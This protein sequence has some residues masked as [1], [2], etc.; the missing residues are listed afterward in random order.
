MFDE[1]KAM[2]EKMSE[3]QKTCACVSPMATTQ[4]LVFLGEKCG[5]K[6]EEL[7]KMLVEKQEEFEKSTLAFAK[8]GLVAIEEAKRKKNVDAINDLK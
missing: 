8:A 7:G 5:I 4:L 3:A 6:P 1:M 2:I